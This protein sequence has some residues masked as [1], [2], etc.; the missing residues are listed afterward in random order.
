MTLAKQLRHENVRSDLGCLDE[1]GLAANESPEGIDAIEVLGRKSVV[2]LRAIQRLDRFCQARRIDLIHAHDAASQFLASLLKLRRS[3][4]RLLMTFHRSLNF[5]SARLRDRMR[6]A[7]ANALSGAIVTGSLERREHF[8]R[9]NI[10]RASKVIRIPFGIETDRF[11]PDPKAR[12]SVRDEL[13]IDKDAMVVGAVGHY[14]PEKG[15]DVVVRA[16]QLIRDRAAP[17]SIVLVILGSGNAEQEQMM[18]ALSASA[19]THRIVLAGFQTDVP[20]WLSAFDVFVH[21]PRS[22]AFGLAL[23]EAMAAGLPVVA[24]RVG[25]IPDIVREGQTGMLV[26]PDAPAELAD[27]VTRVVCDSPLRAAM[28]EKAMRVASAEFG[29]ERYAKRYLGVYQALLDGRT[30]IGVDLDDG[31]ESDAEMKPL[32]PPIEGKSSAFTSNIDA[33]DVMVQSSHGVLSHE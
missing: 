2:D 27:A 10:V 6:N 22:E 23:V 9:A 17:H 21:A 33:E 5:E 29:A 30:P 26:P 12:V 20:R 32:P 25:G 16:F 19:S 15:I 11:K 28:A 7:F 24:T 8:L 13:G 31:Q 1:L 14:G 4:Y 18:R 3:R